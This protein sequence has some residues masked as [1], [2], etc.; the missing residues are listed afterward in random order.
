MT[1]TK[2]RDMESCSA[3][4][5]GRTEGFGAWALRACSLAVGLWLGVGCHGEPAA[6]PVQSATGPV[7]ATSVATPPGPPPEAQGT[8]SASPSPETLAGFAAGAEGSSPAASLSAQDPGPD[9]HKVGEPGLSPSVCSP[10]GVAPYP[11]DARVAKVEATVL[12]RCIVETDGKLTCRM[13]KSHK[14]FDK[15]ILDML[16]KARVPVFTKDGTPVRVA[17]NYTFRFKIQ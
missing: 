4:V 2:A 5:R 1:K 9:I 3:K 17:C 11:E 6:A 7:G 16:A 8:W 15:P 13:V 12:A 14:L 10:A